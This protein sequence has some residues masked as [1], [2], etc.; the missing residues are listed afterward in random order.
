MLSC[1]R[2]VTKYRNELA[3]W[4]VDAPAEDAEAL[5]ATARLL[6]LLR[7]VDVDPAA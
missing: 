7:V 1:L 6:K 5:A 3:H 2:I 4:A